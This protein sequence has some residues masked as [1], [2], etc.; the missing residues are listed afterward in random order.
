[1]VSR[2]SLLVHSCSAWVNTRGKLFSG[3][4]RQAGAPGHRK[5]GTEVGDN[6]ATRSNSITLNDFMYFYSLMNHTPVHLRE[7][8]KRSFLTPPRNRRPSFLGA[9]VIQERG[10]GTQPSFA[11]PMRAA[12]VLLSLGSVAAFG[13]AKVIAGCLDPL[14]TNYNTPGPV[15]LSVPGMCQYNPAPPAPPSAPGRYGRASNL[16]FSNRPPALTPPRT[17]APS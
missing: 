6:R 13:G 16:S 5:T 4:N 14:A 15:T 3:K 9:V 2:V 11:G 8:R 10:A 7:N 17:P 1:M 12:L